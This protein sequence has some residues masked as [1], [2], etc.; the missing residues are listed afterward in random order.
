M[1]GGASRCARRAEA[2]RR[3]GVSHEQSRR[4]AALRDMLLPQGGLLALPRVRG[5]GRDREAL[6]RQP[7]RRLEEGGQR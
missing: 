7:H 3:A 2:A 4:A 1:V 5:D 6:L